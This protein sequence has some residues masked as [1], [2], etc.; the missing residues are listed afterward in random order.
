MAKVQQRQS[1]GKCQQLV[2]VTNSIFQA[3]RCTS[4]KEFNG[5]GS[6]D[7]IPI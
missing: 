5:A 4:H 2:P 3:D 6:K 1:D 7:I